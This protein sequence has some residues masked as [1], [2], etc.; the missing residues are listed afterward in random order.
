MEEAHRQVLS[1]QK[2]ILSK[3]KGGT[4]ESRMYLKEA[5]WSLTNKKCSKGWFRLFKSRKTNSGIKMLFRSGSEEETEDPNEMLAIA[6]KHHLELQQE[7]LMDDNWK[8]AIKVILADLKRSLNEE[9]KD[10]IKKGV[11]YIEIYK[12]I[13]KAPN[14]KVP[15]PDGLLNEFWKQ[16]MK[17]QDE[18]KE[19]LKRHPGASTKS[20]I[21]C[22]ATQMTKVLKDV[23]CFSPL[24]KQ[25][26]EARMG[27]LYKKK[28]RRDIHTKLQTN[29][30]TQHRLQNVHQNYCKPA[31]KSSPQHNPQGSGW[32]YAKM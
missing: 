13:S 12:T 21:S 27:L 11:S 10:K 25:F 19:D 7:P 3:Y 26:S 23:K 17:W 1:N 16:V 5:K 32:I 31:Q 30:T 6:R 28:D 20:P 9:E 15:G 24:D 2:R 29:N 8:R 4:R 22:I 18:V 14:S